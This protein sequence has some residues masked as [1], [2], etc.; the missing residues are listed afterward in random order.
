MTTLEE[1]SRTDAPSEVWHQALT[2]FRARA[3]QLFEAQQER[4]HSLEQSIT[5][6]LDAVGETPATAAA[7]GDAASARSASED[8]ELRTQL[9]QTRK[10]L[11]VRADELKRLRTQLSGAVAGQPETDTA[12]LLDELS[13]LRMERDQLVARVAEAEHDAQRASKG[14]AA[15]LDQLRQ[16]FEKAVQEIRELKTKNAALEADPARNS[17]PQPA[18][19]S[20]SG[21]NWEEQKRL[22]MED[23]DDEP[24]AAGP[25][26]EDRLSIESTIRIT[27]EVVGAKDREIAD[28]RALLNDP[29]AQLGAAHDEGRIADLLD[30]DEMI[31]AEREKLSRLQ[32]ESRE[33]LRRAEIDLSVERA[34]LAR[35]RAELDERARALEAERA[36][37]AAEAG[38]AA[39]ERKSQK[40]SGRWLSRLGLK[41]DDG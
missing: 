22:L 12:R 30:R 10:L 15:Q 37:F 3:Q 17:S 16:R 32:D 35:G 33:K 29:T 4:I 5:E 21:F 31:Q 11:N 39:S 14:D 23:L 8:Q 28:L 34:K 40:Q 27:D 18:A 41:E 20:A 13:E 6:Q 1:T 24:P 7:A 19:S 38:G 9:A 2:R 26:K 36:A 25:P